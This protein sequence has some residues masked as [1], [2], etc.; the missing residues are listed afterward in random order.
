MAADSVREAIDSIRQ[1]LQAELDSELAGLAERQAS[2]LAAARA[3][4]EAEIEQR[5]AAARA[6]A[7]AEVETRLAAVRS[8]AEAEAQ[9]RV[10]AARAAA[11]ADAERRVAAATADA[12]A[13]FERRLAAARAA[14]DA[15]T[16]RRIEAARSAALGPGSLAHAFGQIDA[17][18]S[19]SSILDAIGTAV[20]AA[21]PGAALYVGPA[22]APARWPAGTG[23]GTPAVADVLRTARTARVDDSLIVPLVLGGSAVGAVAAELRG[24]QTSVD[25]IEAIVR[26]GAARLGSVTAMRTG[27]A[28]RWIS[29]RAGAGHAAAEDPA[30]SA[31][32]FARLLVSEI[33]LYNEAAVREGRGQRDL[34]ARLAPE[35][36]RARRVY[37]ERVPTTV[38]D[39]TRYFHQE[40][41]QTLAGGD[42]TLLG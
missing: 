42:A 15:E 19:L 5:L 39:R 7:E 25:T 17:R 10:A 20:A 4:S 6:A 34:A 37:E 23:T 38:P 1:K 9:R 11:E 21:A 28:H 41:V 24:G 32:R 30:Q 2:E 33:K 35:I 14:A 8:A 22:D 16:E 29:T 12:E 31:R 26:Y 18:D 3:A 36:D 27:E 40:L 13:A